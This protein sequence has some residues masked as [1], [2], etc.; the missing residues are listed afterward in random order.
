MFRYTSVLCFIILSAYANAQDMAALRKKHFNLNDGIAL[1]GYDAVAYI[2]DQKA[3]KG[4]KDYATDIQGITYYFSSAENKNTFI[5]DPASYEPQYGGWCAYAMGKNGEKVRVDPQTFK[6]I[7]GKLY[8][9][10][11]RFFNNTLT[12]WENDEPRLKTNADKNWMKI[13][14]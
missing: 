8:L 7:Y 3:V 9:F 13:Y 1:Q 5:K 11:N 12:D 10:Y 6:I 14:K 4:K 2:K